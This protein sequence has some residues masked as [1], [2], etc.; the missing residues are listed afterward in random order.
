MRGENESDQNNP[1]LEKEM[2][3]MDPRKLLFVVLAL[4]FP[5]GKSFL[6]F[7]GETDKNKENFVRKCRITGRIKE[8]NIRILLSIP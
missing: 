2:G 1:I 7:W 5:R 8:R 3:I 6:N 4:V